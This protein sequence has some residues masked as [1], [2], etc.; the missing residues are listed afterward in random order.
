MNILQSNSNLIFRH[1]IVDWNYNI[2]QFFTLLLKYEFKHREVGLMQ[3]TAA[4][5]YESVD[6]NIARSFLLWI[7]VESNVES[8]QRS[9]GYY[10]EHSS[11][12]D[13]SFQSEPTEFQKRV[14]FLRLEIY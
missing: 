11:D 8:F 10:N 12:Y 14:Q 5:R 4:R 3:F 2:K 6:T 13:G 7:F 1:S 9:N